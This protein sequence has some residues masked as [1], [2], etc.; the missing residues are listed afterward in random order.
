MTFEDAVKKIKRDGK[1]RWIVPHVADV[2]LWLTKAG[3]ADN[4]IRIKR[5]SGTIPS[6]GFIYSVS[7][8]R[9]I[10]TKSVLI[11]ERV[12]LIWFV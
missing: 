11:K 12:W 7:V 3:T 1:L 10:G 2:V 9:V 6:T 4:C 5:F 8:V